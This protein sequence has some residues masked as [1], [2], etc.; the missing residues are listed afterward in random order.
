MNKKTMMKWL[1]LMIAPIVLPFVV[2]NIM[3]VNDEKVETVAE[4]SAYQITNGGF[5]TGNLEGWTAYRIWKDEAGNAAFDSSLV[6]S[7][8]YFG[9]NP[10]NRDGSYNLGITSGSISWDQSSERMG[11]LKSSN[12]ILSGSGWISFKI[13]GGRFPEF[14]YVSVHKSSDDEEVARFGNRWFN[15]TSRATTVYGS[16]ISN[17]EAFLFPYYFDLSSVVDLETSLYIKLCDTSAYD[18]SILSADSFVT[19]YAVGN[20]PTPGEDDLAVNILPVIAGV[21]TATNAIVNGYFDSNYDGWTISGSGWGHASNSMR[22]NVVGGDGGTGILRSSAFIVSTDKYIRFDWAGGLKNDKRIYVSIKE[23]STNTEVLRY[24]RRDNLASKENEDFDNHMLN[25][26]SLNA[27]KKYYL[28]FADNITGGWGISYVDS[29]RFVSKTEW[30]SV[31]SGDRAVLISGSVQFARS[32]LEQTAPICE[33]MSGD[34]ST[35]WPIMSSHYASLSNDAKNMFTSGSTTEA[36]IVAARERYLFIANKYSLDKFVV[37]SDNQQYQG[38][39]DII[40][41]DISA[42]TSLIIIV[43]TAAMV[44]SA[45]AFLI[46]SRRRKETM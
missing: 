10:Y 29:I 31:I 5:E 11:Y 7:G 22:S 41:Y 34:F 30:D 32:L 3:A 9:S 26:S 33:A 16:S 18:W 2:M 4:G 36:T 40:G 20:E 27:S 43:V 42:S 13:G 6:T 44:L 24:V 14:A 21:D 8:T 35:V 28:E 12:F 19:Y 39:A 23:V 46:V 17:A 37:N 15:N 45:G 38:S 1:S 25:L